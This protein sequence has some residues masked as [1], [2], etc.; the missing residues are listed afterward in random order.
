MRYSLIEMF[1]FLQNRKPVNA[2][3]ENN[4]NEFF[5]FSAQT[6]PLTY[7]YDQ[8]DIDLL[9]GYFTHSADICSFDKNARDF[10]GLDA[11]AFDTFIHAWMSELSIEN[12]LLA[13]GRRII[14]ETEKYGTPD[15]KRRAA[16]RAASDRSD[17]NTLTVLNAAAKVQS[18]V[19]RMTGLLRFSPDKTGA[20]TAVFTPDYFILAALGQ[21]F[22]DRF[23]D[24]AWAIIDKKRALCLYRL[25]GECAKLARHDEFPF[26]NTMEDGEWEDLWRHYHKTINNE[27]RKNKGLQRQLMPVR[28]WK[29]LPEMQEN[30]GEINKNTD[31]KQQEQ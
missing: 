25:P 20:Y 15:D 11:G 5:D 8:A 10:Y 18:E 3:S 6:P 23:G 30:N 26:D 29:Y 9:C 17:E 31:E 12:E 22:T 1:S 13:F 14:A 27:N 4:Q 16:R 28:Y 7:R 2:K 21:Y 24:T 19:H